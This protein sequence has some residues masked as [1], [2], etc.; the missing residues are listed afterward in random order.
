VAAATTFMA[1]RLR[2]PTVIQE[3]N[4]IPGRTN[5]F[6][7]GHVDR[8]CIAFPDDLG[9]F[10]ASRTVLTGVPI[11][12][13]VVAATT[14]AVAR[15]DLNLDE[16]AFVLLVVGGSQGAQRL[17]QVVAEAA[18]ALPPSVHIVHLTGGANI[19]AA[20]QAAEARSLDRARY[21]AHAFFDSDH[22]A[23]AYAASDAVFCRCG[24][25]TLAETTANGLPLIMTP[26]PT[27]Y[28]DHQ[29]AN[30]RAVEAAGAGVLLPQATLTP[31]QLVAEVTRLQADP[32]ALERVA[33]A[34][35]RF[36]KPN[37]AAVVAGIALQVSNR[38]RVAGLDRS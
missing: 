4:A 36:G 34:S 12:A 24:A 28:A 7:A 8:V 32:V 20:Q 13:S 15:R 10:P 26:L 21:Q 1:T 17:N 27:A 35:R 22:M 6:L 31:A 9:A 23:L 3:Q 19:E 33:S 30:A 16:R 18:A 38:D 37:A 11:R 14:R 25:S 2:I 29:T 5:R